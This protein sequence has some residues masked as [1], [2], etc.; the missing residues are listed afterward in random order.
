MGSRKSA[1]LQKW[2]YGLVVGKP[3]ASPK[4]ACVLEKSRINVE[5]PLSTRYPRM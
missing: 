1:T 5:K 3:E 4:F 2:H